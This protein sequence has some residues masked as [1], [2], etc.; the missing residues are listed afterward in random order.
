MSDRVSSGVFVT[1]V[2]YSTSIQLHCEKRAIYEFR[3]IYLKAFLTGGQTFLSAALGLQENGGKKMG[4]R[5]CFVPLPFWIFLP[6]CSCLRNNTSV[7]LMSCA[8]NL[9]AYFP[10]A[11]EGG[12]ILT[13]MEKK[14]CELPR[15]I[16]FLLFCVFCGSRRPSHLP[17][18]VP[19]SHDQL[20]TESHFPK[21]QLRRT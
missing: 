3:N 12:V 20:P 4:A 9:D 11:T 6:P 18:S 7:T 2:Y 21:L 8:R 19:H 14:L 5:K 16:L 13:R 15:I 17:F 10:R 1:N